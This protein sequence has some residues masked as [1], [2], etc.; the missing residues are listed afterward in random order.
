MS[1][2]KK[3]QRC[4]AIPL[5][6]RRHALATA[7]AMVLAGASAMAQDE[8]PSLKEV[9]VSADAPPPSSTL[10]PDAYKGGQTGKGARMGVLGNM[11]LVNSPFSASS[12][13]SQLAEEQQAQTL[14]DVLLND[15]SVRSASP[16][17]Y[18]YELI[19]LRGFYTQQGDIAFNGLYGIA[20][21]SRIPV[22][23]LERVEVIKGPN[24]LLNG[25]SP[26][27]AGAA[28]STSCPSAPASSRSRA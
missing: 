6:P 18:G 22:D 15:A 4:N 25:M 2:S 1:S 23:M 16:T 3:A 9:T 12:Y 20:P 11:D 28:P 17:N 24:A 27:G 8:T 13:T 26:S 5:A 14:S 21:Y 7:A 10:L 19:N